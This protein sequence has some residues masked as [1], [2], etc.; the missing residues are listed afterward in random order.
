[1]EREK[2]REERI[3]SM[4]NKIEEILERTINCRKELNEHYEKYNGKISKIL[5]IGE[6]ERSKIAEEGLYKTVFSGIN[7]RVLSLL[8]SEKADMSVLEADEAGKR[9]LEKLINQ[10]RR[11]YMKMMDSYKLGIHNLFIPLELS[12]IHI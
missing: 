10:V 9:E 6:Q 1:M 4:L 12:L 5:N 2:E 11:I 3:L 7:P 8:T